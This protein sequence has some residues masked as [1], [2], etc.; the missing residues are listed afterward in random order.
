MIRMGHRFVFSS[1]KMM[2]LHAAGLSFA[3]EQGTWK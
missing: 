3:D 2:A 1:R